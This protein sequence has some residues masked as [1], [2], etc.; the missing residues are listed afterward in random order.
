M[1]VKDIQEKSEKEQGKE[2]SLEE[3]GM[4]LGVDREDIVLALEATSYIE[5]IDKSI[6][7]KGLTS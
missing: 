7:R 3:L 1:K 4:L 5:S 2:M 6:D